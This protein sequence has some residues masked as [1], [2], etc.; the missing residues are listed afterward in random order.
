MM[1]AI[2]S[3]T[4]EQARSHDNLAWEVIVRSHTRYL[5]KLCARFVHNREDLEDLTQEVFIR[6]FKSLDNFCESEG[7]FISW[8]TVIAKNLAIDYCRRK[9]RYNTAF[10]EME[11]YSVATQ[12]PAPLDPPEARLER[13]ER[14]RMLHRG[15]RRMS[16]SLRNVLVMR[17]LEGNSYQE[18]AERLSVPEGTVKSRLSRSRNQFIKIFQTLESETPQRLQ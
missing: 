15:L 5:Y 16:P 3:K 11:D 8:I 10:M 6:V 18:I 7:S 1:S 17:E 9:K 4:L 12:A 2:D 13:E 14:T